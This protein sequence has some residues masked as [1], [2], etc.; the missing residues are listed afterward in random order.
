MRSAR[1]SPSNQTDVNKLLPQDR[2]AHDWYR[3]VLSFPP[4]L[5]RTYLQRFGVTEEHVVLDPFCG[6]GATLVECKKLGISSVGVEAMPMG[7]FATRV[8][9]DWTPD[10]DGLIAHSERVAERAARILGD[11]DGKGAALRRLPE[12]KESLLLADSILSLY[13]RPLSCSTVWTRSLIIPIGLTNA[14]PWPRPS[15]TPSAICTSVRKSGW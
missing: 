13:I 1:L 7:H 4:H 15:S 14:L 9:T 11:G 6:T 3:F 8:K 5:V 12:D 10:P 2:P